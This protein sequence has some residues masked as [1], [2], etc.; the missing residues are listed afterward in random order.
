MTRIVVL[1]SGGGSNL[2]S[3]LDQCQTGS[4]DADIVAVISNRPDAFGLSRARQAG[5]KA[6]TLDHTGYANRAA[7][8]A[9]LAELIEA[10]QP[11]LIVLAGFMRI[12]TDDFVR[13]FPGKMINIH[14]SLLPRYPG[15][16]THQRALDAGDSQ[17]GAT[18][19][20]V[21]AELD[22][23]PPIAQVEVPI[24]DQDDAESLAR[25]VL[26]QEHRL[27]PTVVDWFVKGRLRLDANQ[28]LLDDQPLPKGGRLLDTAS[29]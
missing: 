1:I 27:Y 2:Q 10:Q 15:L 20:F 24:S 12:L 11:D 26:A 21:T 6:L 9:A 28:V 5:V 8:D 3:L 18:V 16:N 4:L 14:P 17:A 22:G 13:R 25:K 7:F 23:G 29:L 19:H